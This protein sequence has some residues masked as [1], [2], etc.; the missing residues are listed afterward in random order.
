MLGGSR[1]AFVG[2]D[3]LFYYV[4]PSGVASSGVRWCVNSPWNVYMGVSTVRGIT[5]TAE[6]GRHR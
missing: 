1:S 2:G 4:L 5:S 3:I 6:S